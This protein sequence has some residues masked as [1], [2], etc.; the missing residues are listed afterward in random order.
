MECIISVDVELAGRD[1]EKH[2]ILSF[3]A[4]VVGDLDSHFYREMQPLSLEYKEGAVRIAAR[5][6]Y[7]IPPKL[8]KRPEYGP[9]NRDFRPE[10]IMR[11]LYRHGAPA[12]ESF[13]SFIHWVHK[14][15][16]RRAS[17]VLAKPVRI[18]VTILKRYFTTFN[19]PWPFTREIDLEE[20]FRALL[21][22][23]HASL[24]NLDV[25]YVR[26]HR[27]NALEDCM[28]QAEQ[29]RKILQI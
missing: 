27:H 3:G 11:Y 22:T 1:L 9:R 7:C 14:S 5:G 29:Y 6:L 13:E 8:R 10:L 12:H 20:V 15:S 16:E 18:D 4:C 28:Y 2:S 19:L 26:R 21:G 25:S 17:A 23:P 24:R